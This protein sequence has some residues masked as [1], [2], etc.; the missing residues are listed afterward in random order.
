[1][2]GFSLRK[3]VLL[4]PMKEP[5]EVKFTR[6]LNVI[7]GPSDTGKSFIAQ[8]LDYA[9]GSG[10][11]PKEIP[12]ADGYN[13][14]VLEIES[15]RDGRIYTLERGLGGGEVMCRTDGEPNRVLAAKHEG[16][17]DDTV[18]QFLLDLSG[19]GT[20][21]VRTNEQGKT[22]PLSF[23]DIA[24]LVIIDE[25]TV[26]KED[27]PVLSGQVIHKTV[28]GGVFRLLLT[29]S[30]DSSIIA[31]EDKKISQGRRAGQVEL[32]ERMLRATLERRAEHGHI[33]TLF[34]EKSRLT[35]LDVAINAAVAERDAALVAVAPLQMKRN[36]AWT[37][38][39][40]IDSKLVVISELQTRF[41]L[42]QEQYAS[43]LRRLEAIAE[44]G[45]RL[46]QLREERCPI[47]GALAEHHDHAHRESRPSP[48]EIS[49]ACKAEAAKTFKLLHDLQVT[50][51]ATATNIEQ[52]R[53]T[54]DTQLNTVNAISEELK[55]Q[56]EQQVAI[57]SKN[58]DDLRERSA[59]CRRAIEHLE[60]VQEL[61]SLLDAAERKKTTSKS[62]AAGAAVSAAQADPFS[63]EVEELLRAWHFPDLG[64]VTFSDT[65]QDVVISGRTR[66]SRGKG[67]RAITRAA[68]NLALLRLC[69]NDERP[70]PNFVLVDSPL[71]VYEEPDTE[72]PTFPQD[73]KWHFWQSVRTSFTDAQ[74]II[75]E[76]S[77]QLP[78]DGTLGDVK[79]TIFTGSDQ[80]R[81][82]FIPAA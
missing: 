50:R 3:L 42:L 7:A 21:K 68:F 46:D 33:G 59:L 43:D 64:R 78:D 62:E 53:R 32:L 20:K 72:E 70:F 48:T 77:R 76:N 45:V 75:I 5:A 34:E 37:E 67:V 82:G 1:M 47:C 69:I 41:N 71:L 55:K 60:R 74:V 27:S 16:G 25:V 49:N 54:R 13:S 39:R 40:A 44:T 17:K 15:N 10:K 61:E 30:D 38:L 57:A 56:M 4:G 11:Q 51:A 29:G 66:K 26:I 23:R 2:F 18:S 24:R 6:G 81:R 22:R 31:K 36:T 58:V 35:R 9:L 79:V 63:R 65:D 73:V 14:V 52:L 19:L 80:G 12:E 8:C 28:E